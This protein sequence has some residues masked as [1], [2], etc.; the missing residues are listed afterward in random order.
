M[1]RRLTW[2]EVRA[3]L[4]TVRAEFKENARVAGCRV[5]WYA[6]AVFWTALPCAVVLAWVQW[7]LYRRNE[8]MR[9]D[10]DAESAART[11]ADCAGA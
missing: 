7:C 4:V 8:E 10:R 6:E 1:T 11:P 2:K 3:F 5:D 9:K